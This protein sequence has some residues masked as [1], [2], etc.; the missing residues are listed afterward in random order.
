MAYTGHSKGHWS[1]RILA[2]QDSQGN[3]Q[4]ALRW[5]WMAADIV[6]LDALT[7]PRQGYSAHLYECALLSTDSTGRLVQSHTCPL[8]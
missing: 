5:G 1:Q 6:G 4:L 8:L 3:C 7:C 2:A